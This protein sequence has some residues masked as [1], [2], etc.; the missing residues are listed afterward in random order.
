V[1]PVYNSRRAP[2]LTAAM[3]LHAVV[4]FVFFF[5]APYLALPCLWSMAPWLA[6]G[7]SESPASIYLPFS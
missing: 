7:A 1:L 4:L 5:P 6:G 2:L 3:A